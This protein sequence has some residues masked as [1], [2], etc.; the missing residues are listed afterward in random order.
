VNDTRQFVVVRHGESVYN[1]ENRFTGWIDCEL[2]ARGVREA[3]LAGALLRRQGFRFDRI[4]T[5][6][7]IRCTESARIIGEELS[8][9]TPIVAKNWR[10]NERHYGA[11]QGLNKAETA[12]RFGEEQVRL[13][14]RSYDVRP[15]AMAADDAGNPANAPQ[16]AQVPKTLLPLTE[17]LADVVVRVVPFWRDE[18]APAIAAGGRVLVVAHGNSIRALVKHLDR[19]SD[20]SIVELNIPTGQPFVYDMDARLTPLARYYLSERAEN[21]PAPDAAAAR[22]NA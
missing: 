6:V 7:L 20:A 14:R 11:L 1:A 17:S 10:L 13:W 21:D 19:I 9:P 5:S 2:T 15:P 3:H 18:I 22:S 12:A 4:Y 8:P 16:Y